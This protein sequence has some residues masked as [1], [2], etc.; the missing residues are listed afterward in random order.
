[1]GLR[2]IVLLGSVYGS[3]PFS[4]RK[5]FFG[6]FVWIWLSL[7]NPHRISW[8][9]ANAQLA[10]VAALTMLISILIS[11]TEE[12][13]IPWN[14]ITVLLAWWWLWILITTLFA[15][16]PTA[17]WVQWDVVW[18]TMLTTFVI[19]MMLN[20]KERLIAA[21]VVMMLSLGFFGFQ[22]GLFHA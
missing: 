13:K 2:D 10:Q 3:V 1:M 12:K 6:V 20:T 4:L 7:M 11:R 15:S 22:R 9:L 5:P 18:K 17:A 8:N 16:N 19:V 21:A 14:V